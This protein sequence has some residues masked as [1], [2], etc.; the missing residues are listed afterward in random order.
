MKINLFESGARIKQIRT[1]HHYSM[2]EFAKILDSKSTSSVNDW[3][4]GRNLPNKQRLE[5][6]ALLGSTTVEWIKYG[7]FSNY[8][9]QLTS[10]IE[11]KVLKKYGETTLNNYREALLDELMIEKVTY[12][13]DTKILSAAEKV[14]SMLVHSKKNNQFESLTFDLTPEKI[15]DKF[16]NLEISDFEIM[17]QSLIRNTNPS[18]NKGNRSVDAE[19]RSTASMLYELYKKNQDDF[20]LYR[21]INKKD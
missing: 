8:V 15:R 5:K 3:E 18:Y 6:I 9:S 21:D 17:C 16:A 4:K 11:A 13:E 19:I 10:E 12:E 20:I 14:Y 2:N 1:K 7:D